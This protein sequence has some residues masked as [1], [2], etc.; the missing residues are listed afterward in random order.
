[1]FEIFNSIKSNN[2]FFVV[3]CIEETLSNDL[4]SGLRLLTDFVTPEEESFL[5]HSINWEQEGLELFP[6]Q[7]F[8][9]VTE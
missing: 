4:P 3:P 9:F 8:S 5:L 6:L 7:L 1:M 2:D